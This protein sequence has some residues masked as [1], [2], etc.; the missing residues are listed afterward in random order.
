VACASALEILQSCSAMKGRWN[1]ANNAKPTA[2]TRAWMAQIEMDY[3]L[4][5]AET[6]ILRLAAQLLDR[7]NE[8]RQAVA[9]DCPFLRSSRGALCPHPGLRTEVDVARAFAALIKQLGLGDLDSS[10]RGS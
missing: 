5:S 4:T 10:F 6:E 9:K 1:M 2:K 8:A 3:T 7:M